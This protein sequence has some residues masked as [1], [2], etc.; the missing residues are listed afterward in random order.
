MSYP[1]SPP[2]IAV[3]VRGSTECP[4]PYPFILLA[5]EG[6]P[7]AAIVICA[8]R[9]IAV[10]EKK[11]LREAISVCFCVCELSFRPK[12]FSHS[13]QDDIKSCLQ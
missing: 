3:S 8:E 4:Y 2:G 7:G 13:A 10:N 1:Y 5:T 12:L 11:V 6:S 9:R